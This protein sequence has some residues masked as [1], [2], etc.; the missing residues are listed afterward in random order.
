M[1]I[2]VNDTQARID[3]QRADITLDVP[4]VTVSLSVPAVMVGIAVEETAV[5][6][7]QYVDVPFVTGDHEYYRG[8]YTVTPKR[9]EQVLATSNKLMA[10]DVTVKEIPYS[11]TSNTAGGETFYIARSDA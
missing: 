11:V 4:Q 3:V 10:Q 7:G 8:D 5:K 6:L 2:S 9:E 1:Q